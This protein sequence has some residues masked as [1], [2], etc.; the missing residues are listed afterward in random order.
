VYL[1]EVRARRQAASSALAEWVPLERTA[2]EAYR[3]HFRQLGA[4]EAQAAL[5]QQLESGLIPALACAQTLA[6]RNDL[7]DEVAALVNC[8]IQCLGHIAD[9]VSDIDGARPAYVV[10][11][12]GELVALP[13][14]PTP[15][16][17]T[18]EDVV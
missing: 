2:A 17:A 3:A 6:R 7:S 9:V 13:S 11:G 18:S 14:R 1:D 8:L 15:A 12:R 5:R 10:R 4:E 16:D